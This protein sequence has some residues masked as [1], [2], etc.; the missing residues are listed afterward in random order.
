[1]SHVTDHLPTLLFG[2]VLGWAIG[3]HFAFHQLPACDKGSVCVTEGARHVT[4][5]R[6]DP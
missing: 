6:G 5:L 1:M 4:Y 2:L 3:T